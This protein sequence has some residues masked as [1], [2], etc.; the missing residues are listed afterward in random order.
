MPG[1]GGG[2]GGG[3]GGGSRGGGFGGGFGGGGHRG[4]YHG[5]HHY[6][7]PRFGGWFFGPRYHYYGGGC[8]GGLFGLLFVP[9]I[10]LLIIGAMLVSSI[11]VALGNVASGGQVVYEESVMQE[12]ADDQYSEIFGEYD[13]YENNILIVFLTNAEYDG[14]Y[15]I[16]WVGYNLN[17]RIYDM[18][19]GSESDFARMMLSTVNGEYYKNSLDKDLE[20]LTDKLGSKIDSF[21]LTSS[22]EDDYSYSGPMPTSRLYNKSTLA[23]NEE[24]VNEA[25][26]EFTEL[27]GIP[28]AIVVDE[29]EDALGKRILME[30]IML[31]I[32]FLAI[33][34][35]SVYLVIRWN[36]ERKNKKNENQ[37]DSQNNGSGNDGYNSNSSGGNYGFYDDGRRW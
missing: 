34:G 4:G 18:F 31:V 36:K 22:F 27:T 1:P 14:Y 8:L 11:S 13:N 29:M 15:A 2:G 7:G 5:H 9:A 35:V 37:N 19:G 20:R 28:A 23:M 10:M 17:Y 6:H 24:M 30:D 33:L 32:I 12:Y 16:G 3:F 21:N 26:A 25:L